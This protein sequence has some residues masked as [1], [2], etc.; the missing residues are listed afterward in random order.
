MAQRWEQFNTEKAESIWEKAKTTANITLPIPQSYF[1]LHDGL[2]RE[3]RAV[4][5]DPINVHTVNE[6][7]QQT[8]RNGSQRNAMVGLAVL[9]QLTAHS[10]MPP[11]YAQ[12]SSASAS[13]SVQRQQR[14]STHPKLLSTILLW[15]D[16]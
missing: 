12:V 5:R 1:A 9:S 7:E 14:D 10:K 13:S 15:P 8:A 16:I 11:L 4:I 2:Q 6:G 3:D